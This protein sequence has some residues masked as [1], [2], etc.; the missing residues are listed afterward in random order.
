[1]TKGHR[2]RPLIVKLATAYFLVAPLIYLLVFSWFRDRTLT[3]GFKLIPDMTL[4][5][6]MVLAGS[7]VAALLT[8]LVQTWAWYALLGYCALAIY[9][10]WKNFEIATVFPG[11]AILTGFAVGSAGLLLFVQ[12]EVRS[13]YLNPRLCWW[14]TSPRYRVDFDVMVR[15]KEKGTEHKVTLLDISKTG[16]FVGM[17][18]DASVGQNVEIEIGELKIPIQGTVVRSGFAGARTNPIEGIGVKFYST[19][20]ETTRKVKTFVAQL[21]GN[22]PHRD[23][24][25][26]IL[27]LES[28]SGKSG[29]APPPQ[30]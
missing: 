4:A 3:S 24:P 20:L 27:H 13:P 30:A 26:S 22:A 7:W 21:A 6:Q 11:W 12:R 18:P 15:N 28:R 23:E 2:Q 1:M 19:P 9:Q 8:W 14:K 10:V 5:S 17:C 25:K 29:T 16:C